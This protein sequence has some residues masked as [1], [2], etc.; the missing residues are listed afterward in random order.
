MESKSEVTHADDI[1][2]L[3][4]QLGHECGKLPQVNID[5]QHDLSGGMYARTGV[6]KAGCLLIGAR[7]KTDHINIM[8]GDISVTTDEGVKRLVGYHVLPTKA[9]RSRAGVAHSDT[10]WT[11]ICK[12]DETDISKIED[13]L[14]VESS[15]LQSRR[16]ELTSNTEGELLCSE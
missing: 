14:V 8:F 16:P 3:V 5:L 2:E 9:G 15:Q 12:T 13:E 11:T 6:I 10:V 4:R 7:H 1:N